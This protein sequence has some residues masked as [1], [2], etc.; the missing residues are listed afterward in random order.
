MRYST[1]QSHITELL[2][3]FIVDESKFNLNNASSFFHLDELN[4]SIR[5][6]H[7]QRA[8]DANS[9]MRGKTYAVQ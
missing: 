6:S 1:L 3:L 8:D 2:L 5:C 4:Q 9:V 7:L